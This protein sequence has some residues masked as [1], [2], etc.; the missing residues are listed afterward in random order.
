MLGATKR[1]R[2]E[3]QEVADGA[4]LTS[5]FRLVR[6]RIP[7]AS[8]RCACRARTAPPSGSGLMI[9]C[10][11]LVA[12][13]AQDKALALV[14]EQQ[15]E[16]GEYY[17]CFIPP[18]CAVRSDSLCPRGCRH[19]R[20]CTDRLHTELQALR[21]A[22]VQRAAG[23]GAGAAGAAGAAPPP[24][25]GNGAGGGT[26]VESAE[27]AASSRLA[28]QQE[29]ELARTR[30]E[31]ASERL[32][33]EELSRRHTQLQHECGVLEQGRA[34]LVE[35]LDGATSMLQ[36][37]AAVAGGDAEERQAGSLAREV[38][39]AE[40]APPARGLPAARRW[41]DNAARLRSANTCA[42]APVGG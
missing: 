42:C 38:G 3:L 27:V 20:A 15:S 18:P 31:L 1:R 26:G 9:A 11:L 14:D 32:R 2:E 35:Q 8:V 22:D 25:V 34:R 16:I 19:R 23:A 39:L 36:S 7:A 40:A 24:G 12:P 13:N 10:P 41:P 17:T 30:A 33:S 29:A 5:T 4:E 6:R 37:A 28:R 21:R